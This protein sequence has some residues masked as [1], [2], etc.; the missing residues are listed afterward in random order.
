MSSS[1][2]SNPNDD[3]DD[4][5]VI[6]VQVESLQGGKWPVAPGITLRGTRLGVYGWEGGGSKRTSSSSSSSC[7]YYYYCY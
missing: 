3:D 4:D 7:Y 1:S 6:T 2:S 5:G